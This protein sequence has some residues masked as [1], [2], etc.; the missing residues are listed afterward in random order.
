M[1]K[2]SSA[3]VSVVHDTMILTAEQLE[4]KYGIEIDDDGSVWD[5]YE[6]KQFDNVQKWAVYTD[7]QEDDYDYDDDFGGKDVR[8]VRYRD[9]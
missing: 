6:G 7:A 1:S 5:P 4:D 8:K 3:C 9:D 2:H